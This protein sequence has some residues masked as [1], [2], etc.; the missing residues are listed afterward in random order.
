MAY[1]EQYLPDTANQAAKSVYVSHVSGIHVPIQI[2][3]AEIIHETP[4]QN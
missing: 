1:R 2:I 4:F 3:F